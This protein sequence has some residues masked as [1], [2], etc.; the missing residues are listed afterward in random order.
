MLASAPMRRAA[1]WAL[2]I[3]AVLATATLSANAEMRL[4]RS[5]IT[6]APTYPPGCTYADPAY[7]LPDECRPM[8]TIETTAAYVS[9]CTGVSG[10][11]D[12][13]S[14]QATAA[15][16]THVPLICPGFDQDLQRAYDCTP[17]AR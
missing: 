1:V 7:P 5:D 10:E 14:A 6:P 11:C 9:A 12:F 15:V 8:L 17:T 3:L 16:L 4:V 2:F 13:Q